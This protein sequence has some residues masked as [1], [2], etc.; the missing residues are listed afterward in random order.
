MNSL[1][2][3][4]IILPLLLT[5]CDKDENN[6]AKD[7]SGEWRWI[8]TNSTYPSEPLTPQNTGIQKLMV[9]N[10]NLIFYKIE[11]GL[12][13]DS[14]TYVIGH[15]SYTPYIGAYTYI[16][17]SIA[18]YHNGIKERLGDYYEISN[19]TMI[20][21]PFFSGKFSS[22]SISYSGAIYLIKEN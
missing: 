20:I 7:I 16:Y 8:K 4:L 10:S 19:D 1:F 13:T 5:G 3:I 9:F 6:P 14:G 2:K 15:G 22:Y 21:C 17:D 18:Y 12:K 11:N